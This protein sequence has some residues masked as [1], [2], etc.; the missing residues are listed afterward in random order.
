M[1]KWEYLHI[2]RLLRIVVGKGR[3]WYWA[4]NED[5]KGPIRKRLKNLGQD[6]WELVS[7]TGL[8]DP[9]VLGD[10]TTRLDFYFKRPIEE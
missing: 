3:E 10:Q 7:V 4:D 9:L 2:I 1:Q 8:I 6:G 5:L